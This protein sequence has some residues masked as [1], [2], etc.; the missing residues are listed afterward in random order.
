[1]W[2]KVAWVAAALGVQVGVP[3]TSTPRLQAV[4]LSKARAAVFVAVAAIVVA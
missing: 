4:P 2:A 3:T 1:M